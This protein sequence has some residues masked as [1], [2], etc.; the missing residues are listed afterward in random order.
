MSE[1]IEHTVSCGNVFADLGLPNAEELFLKS[2]LAIQIQMLCERKGLTQ[3]QAAALLRLDEKETLLWQRGEMF[4]LSIERLFQCINRLGHSIEV[5][6]LS[7]EIRPED[8]RLTLMM[9]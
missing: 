3:A 4:S 2:G 8:A 6:I 7:K 9:A 5:R 1:T